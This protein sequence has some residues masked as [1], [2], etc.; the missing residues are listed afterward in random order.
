MPEGEAMPK[1]SIIVA[2]LNGSATIERCI[3]SIVSQSWPNKELLVIDGGS[4]DDT[5]KIIEN[6]AH[7]IAFWESKP[8]RGIYHAWNKA[9]SH[10]TGD[11]LCFLGSDDYFWEKDV[12]KKMVPWLHLARQRGIRL[13][14][15]RLASIGRTGKVQAFLGAPWEKERGLITHQMPP[16]PGM[17]HH[18]NFFK[19]HGKFDESFRIAADYE[20]ML[21]ELADREALFVPDVVVAAIRYGGVSNN[22]KHLRQLI[23]EDVRARRKNGMKALTVHSL[24]YYVALL[25]NSLFY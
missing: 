20:I 17:L 4:T 19:D 21:R 9:L 15:G 14:Y 2:V 7:Q 25:F 10:A 3:E 16:H 8:D 1:I 11:W 18:S 6:K 22:I 12:L 23:R 13:V 5:V 24:K